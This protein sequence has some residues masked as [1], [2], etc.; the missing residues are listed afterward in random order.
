MDINSSRIRSVPRMDITINVGKEEN[1]S[2]VQISGKIDAST[3][4]DLEDTLIDLID[5]G[6]PNIILDLTGTT[7]I[8]SA[9]L[10]VLIVATKQVYDT[11]HFCLCN[12]SSNVL[13]IIEMAG[14]NLFMNVYDNLATAKQG[15]AEN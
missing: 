10:R 3:S 12:V 9:G 2:V 11:G 1:C 8:S 4:D 6:E 15:I 14:F 13:E 7:Y 5:Q